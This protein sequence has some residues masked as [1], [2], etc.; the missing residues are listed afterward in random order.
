MGARGG[1]FQKLREDK[2]K[3]KPVAPRDIFH[4]LPKAVGIND[5]YVSQ[6]EALDAWYPSRRNDKDVVVKLHTGRKDPGCASHGT[7]NHE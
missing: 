6:A 4:S 7:I 2:A 3:P 5:L 1:R